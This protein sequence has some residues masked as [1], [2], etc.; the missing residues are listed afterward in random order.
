MIKLIVCYRMFCELV[1]LGYKTI[2]F[3]TETLGL[4]KLYF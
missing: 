1:C 4:T 3:V 2:T